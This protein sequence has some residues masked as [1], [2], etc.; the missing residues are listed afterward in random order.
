MN[1]SINHEVYLHKSYKPDK[2][3]VRHIINV[4][5]SSEHVPI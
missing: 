5:L 4:S 2:I 3:K 1:E